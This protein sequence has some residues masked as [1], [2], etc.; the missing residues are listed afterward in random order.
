MGRPYVQ[1][2]AQP[3]RGTGYSPPLLPA[4]LGLS[5]QCVS[6]FPHWA[7][8]NTNRS[9]QSLNH[10][11]KRAG[12]PKLNRP[13]SVA[14]GKREL[15]STVPEQ[16]L[17]GFHRSTVGPRRALVLHAFMLS[18]VISA[19]PVKADA[20]HVVYDAYVGGANAMRLSA[21]LHF[22][23][24]GYKVDVQARTLGLLDAF[25]GSRQSTQVNGTWHGML[26]KPHQF[27]TD[28][29]WKGDRR[30]TLIDFQDGL[31]SIRSMIPPEL[32]REPVPPSARQNALDRISPLAYL[33]R[34]VGQT[35]NCDGITTTYDGRRLEETKARTGGWDELS[36]GSLSIFT[37]RA[38]RCDIELRMT[39]GF[40][41][42][43]DR[44]HAG[45][46]RRAQV[47]VAAPVHGAPSLPVLIKLDVG[48][49]GSATVY[50][51][52]LRRAG[53]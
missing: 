46:I 37:G 20:W 15:G 7:S 23:H 31:P 3:Q 17:C 16:T 11:P 53:P 19:G 40:T 22:D 45:R 41:P 49:L 47:W 28:G 42:D 34:R 8:V 24:A 36:P 48:W 21:D 33:A 10:K 4:S 43:E 13:W 27:R 52:G 30:I 1:S 44:A 18:L 14:T 32:N 50:L 2:T 51:S 26:P 9:I 25:V 29:V 35:G 39:G 12:I 5:R 6:I 38:L